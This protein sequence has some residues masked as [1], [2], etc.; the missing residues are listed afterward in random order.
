[1]DAGRMKKFVVFGVAAVAVAGGA[2][3]FIS[4]KGVKDSTGPSAADIVAGQ[5]LYVESCASCH[6]VGLK[7]QPDWQTPGEDGILPAPPHDF[8]GHTWHHSDSVL[9]DYTKLGGKGALAKMGVDD[10][11]SGMPAFED[12]LSDQD[13]WNVLGYIKSTWPDQARDSQSKRSAAEAQ[14]GG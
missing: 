11:E 9:F 8:S 7:G 1:M 3:W 5:T 14:T 6:G 10:F 12:V 2:F 4:S 13:I